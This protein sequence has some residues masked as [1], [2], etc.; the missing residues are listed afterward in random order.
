M[1]LHAAA[2]WK[3]IEREIDKDWEGYLFRA[4][5]N[6]IATSRKNGI[7][8]CTPAGFKYMEMKFRL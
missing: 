4:K 5:K 2:P 8:V 7:S 6:N 3:Y 1:C